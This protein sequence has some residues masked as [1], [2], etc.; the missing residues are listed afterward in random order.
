MPATP[1][2]V[3]TG[4]R[5]CVPLIAAGTG[6][7][8]EHGAMYTLCRDCFHLSDDE[9]WG[10]KS[11]IDK[12][13]YWY[14]ISLFSVRY[15]EG[16]NQE[17]VKDISDL[18]RFL[19]EGE[20]KYKAS[21]QKILNR[22]E[23]VTESILLRKNVEDKVFEPKSIRMAILQFILSTRPYDFCIPS[24]EQD[25]PKLSAWRIANGIET[26]IHHIIP[27][28]HAT[29]IGESTRELRDKPYH[30]LNSA[31]N[32]AYI[33]KQANSALSATSP[34]EYTPMIEHLANSSHCLPTPQTFRDN[35]EHKHYDNI[36]K[37]RF[38]LIMQTIKQKL[39]TLNP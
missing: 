5:V 39:Q 14:W 30:V 1:E 23:L 3:N 17:C 28:G 31:L 22:E 38:N 13:E 11:K 37:E 6:T 12:L 32:L 25:T 35:L 16:Q 15:S 29:T 20:N 9:V 27:L 26:E 33:S 34:Q 19:Y 8:H 21:I 18:G 7:W 10:S 24:Q 36:L 2:I 4:L